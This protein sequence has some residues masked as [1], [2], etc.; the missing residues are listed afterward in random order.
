MIKTVLI[1][2]DNTLLD[3]DAGTKLAIKTLFPKYGI[4][5]SDGVLKTFAS[6]NAKLW[7]K[8]EKG[9]LTKDE[10]RRIRWNTI[11]RVL[12]VECDGEK[13]EKDYEDIVANTAVPIDGSEELLKYLKQNFS[14]YAV[15]NGFVKLQK[16]RLALCSFDKYFDGLFISEEIGANKPS[17]EFFD[18][19]F[20]ALSFPEKESVILIGDSLSADISGGNAYGIKTVLFE[21]NPAGKNTDIIPTFTVRSLREIEKLLDGLAC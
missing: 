14:V 18:A 4:P 20:K 11:F 10:L 19:V 3:F 8:I 15:T 16:K 1:D 13:F 12:G 5:Y 6:E 21:N 9:E 17:K 7:D 2:I